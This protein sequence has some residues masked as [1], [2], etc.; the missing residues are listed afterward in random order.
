[1]HTTDHSLKPNALTDDYSALDQRMFWVKS[2]HS[3]RT[4]KMKGKKGL[5][6]KILPG[7]KW[8]NSCYFNSHI[9]NS[10]ICNVAFPVILSNEGITPNLNSLKQNYKPLQLVVRPERNNYEKSQCS[11]TL[12]QLNCVT[13]TT[14]SLSLLHNVPYDIPELNTIL[15][16][17]TKANGVNTYGRYCFFFF[18]KLCISNSPTQYP[19]QLP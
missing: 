16:S 13:W 1:M 19:I 15:I 17:C 11:V 12:L 18:S 7:R 5:T 8:K 2:D 3:W 10:L 4:T 14:P 9:N 6:L